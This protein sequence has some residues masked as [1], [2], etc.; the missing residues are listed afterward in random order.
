[1][2]QYVSLVESHFDK[3]YASAYLVLCVL[4]CRTRLILYTTVTLFPL[5]SCTL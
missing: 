1:M 4:V 2:C 3:K 5:P